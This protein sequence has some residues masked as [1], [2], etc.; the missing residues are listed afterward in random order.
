MSS[1]E[2]IIA[3]SYTQP[4]IDTAELNEFQRAGIK[5]TAEVY[6]YLNWGAY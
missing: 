3:R 1:F 6:A 2:E 5:L 4:E